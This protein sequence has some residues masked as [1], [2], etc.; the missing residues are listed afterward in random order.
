M[1]FSPFFGLPVLVLFL[2][3]GCD[4][5]GNGASDPQSYASDATSSVLEPDLLTPTLV[6]VTAD[7]GIQFQHV[8]GAQ[9]DKWM[10]ETVGSGGGFLDYDGDGWLD[11][12]LVNGRS[13]SGRDS[14]GTAL[15]RNQGDGTFQDVSRDMGVDLNVYGMGASFGDY[16]GDGD[17]DIYV[18]AVGANVLLRNDGT[19]FRDVTVE[20]GVDGNPVDRQDAWSMGS[21]WLDYDRDDDLDLFVCNYVRWT[22]QTDVFHTLDGTSKAYATPEVYEGDTCVLYR[23]EGGSTFSDV[24][25]AVGLW[26]DTGKALGVIVDD[27][28]ADGWPDLLVTNDTE[29]NFYYLNS[30]DGTFEDRGVRSGIAFD[31]TGRARAGMGADVTD[32]NGDG[33]LAVA[34][35]NFSQESVS[36]YAQLEPE[37][38]QDRSPA[39]RLG[40]PTLL[41]LT[42]GVRFADLNLDGWDDLIL[43]NGHIEPTVAEVH[44]EITFAQSPQIFLRTGD[45]FVD[46]GEATGTDFNRPLVGRGLAVG[47]YDRD[48]DPD[49][50]ITTNGG[51]PR[52]FRSDSPPHGRWVSVRL[53][54]PPGNR[55]GIGAVVYVYSGNRRQR[56]YVTGSGSYLT[57]SETDRRSFGLGNQTQVD[58]VRVTWP[59]GLSEVW[60]NP[61]SAG[62]SVELRHPQSIRRNDQD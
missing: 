13:W 46:S 18:T 19:R 10:P 57:Q 61:M 48:G 59:D 37:L 34:I 55:Q 49:I 21:A 53:V 24:T 17:P 43:A 11:V 2:C 31:P 47:D 12:F 56:W 58:S 26:N 40:R 44:S 8:N 39:M 33:K 54:G 3:V 36:L 50:L 14:G 35:G 51:S 52:L 30:A 20:M 38:F 16:D 25:R 9:G 6:D 7:A 41:S 62:S 15:F 22:P 42:F 60:S 4:S 28:N 5:R 29:P 32:L 1:K 23:N 27:F 45:R